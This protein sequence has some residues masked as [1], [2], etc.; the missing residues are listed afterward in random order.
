MTL[1]VTPGASRTG[2]AGLADTA[3]GGRALKLSVT[4]VAEE[5]RAN[6]AVIKFLAKTWR[7]PKSGLTLVAGVT[8]RN[9]IIHVSGSP[10]HLMPRLIGVLPED[11]RS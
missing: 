2:F 6:D 10:E 1:R 11:Q 7:V 3:N 5:G 8:D 9:K 4:A